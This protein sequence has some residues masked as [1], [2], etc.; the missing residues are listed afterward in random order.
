MMLLLMVGLGQL[1]Q[2]HLRRTRATLAHRPFVALPD[3]KD[4]VVFPGKDGTS[5]LSLSCHQDIYKAIK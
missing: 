5:H 3:L 4:A 2:S 1:L